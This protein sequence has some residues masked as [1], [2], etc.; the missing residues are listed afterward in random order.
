MLLVHMVTIR[1]Y[2]NILYYYYLLLCILLHSM[3]A[4]YA[5]IPTT[6]LEYALFAK[7]QSSG[8]TSRKD[9]QSREECDWIPKLLVGVKN[10]KRRTY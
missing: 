4:I 2:T 3:S 10:T 1:S 9:E 5:F 7:I 6:R 8:K